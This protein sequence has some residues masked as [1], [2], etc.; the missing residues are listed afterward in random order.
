MRMVESEMFEEI[1]TN[2][3]ESRNL[4]GYLIDD[5]HLD[6]HVLQRQVLNDAWRILDG[7]LAMASRGD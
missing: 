7:I 5:V 6:D 1:L 3:Q 4:I 2:V